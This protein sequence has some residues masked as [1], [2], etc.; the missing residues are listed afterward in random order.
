VGQVKFKVVWTSAAV[1]DVRDIYEY[2]HD[3][4]GAASANKLMADFLA[5]TRFLPEFSRMYQVFPS[6]IEG[7]LYIVARSTWRVRWTTPRIAATLWPYSRKPAGV[8][9]NLKTAV[10]RF[11]TFA[12][13]HGH[14]VFCLR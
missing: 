10:D 11:F 13:P 1:A 12:T 9:L 14:S 5:S 8:I 7:T 6:A 2:V 4:A 3:L